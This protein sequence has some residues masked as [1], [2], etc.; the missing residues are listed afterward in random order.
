MKNSNLSDYAIK[1]L[2][3]RKIDSDYQK[4]LRRENQKRIFFAIT[5]ALAVGLLIVAIAC[6]MSIDS[7][8][9]LGSFTPAIVFTVLTISL[10]VYAA[11]R[12]V[13]R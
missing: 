3:Q 10:T 2:A 12:G 8:L 5:D 7:A 11:F 9:D 13:L 1:R 4:E 6:L